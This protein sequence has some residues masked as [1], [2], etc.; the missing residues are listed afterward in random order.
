LRGG[1]RSRGEWVSQKDGLIKNDGAFG[2]RES[3]GEFTADRTADSSGLRCARRRNDKQFW[4]AGQKGAILPLG[5]RKPG[6]R[7][8]HV[9]GFA[10]D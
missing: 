6:T 10:D 9:P 2:G 7:G 1:Y 8:P 3:N 4:E 5:I